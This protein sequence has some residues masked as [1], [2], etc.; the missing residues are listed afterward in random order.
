MPKKVLFSKKVPKKVLKKALGAVGNLYADSRIF[1]EILWHSDINGRQLSYVSYRIGQ[2]KTSARLILTKQYLCHQQWWQNSSWHCDKIGHKHRI[3]R[4]L[5]AW[6]VQRNSDTI[7][8]SE[9]ASF[10]TYYKAACRADNGPLSWCFKCVWFD[11]AVYFTQNMKVTPTAANVVIKSSQM[12]ERVWWRQCLVCRR[13]AAVDAKREKYFR[14][15]KKIFVAKQKKTIC[16]V[17]RPAAVDAKRE[18][19]LLQ[20][21]KNICCKTYCCKTKENYLSGLQTCCSWRKKKTIKLNSSSPFFICVPKLSSK[22][23]W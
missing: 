2:M 15:K 19:Y 7:Y 23:F 11:I 4:F 20:K 17:Y 1:D 12:A 8:Q 16:L 6:S 21:K 3:C 14:Q 13:P 18:K 5:L 22:S 9:L 10:G